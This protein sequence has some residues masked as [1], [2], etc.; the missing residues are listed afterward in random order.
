M[1]NP[2]PPGWAEVPLGQ[3]AHLVRGVTYQKTEARDKPRPGYRPILRAANIQ[4]EGLVLKQDLIYLPEKYIRPGQFLQPGDVVICMSSGSPQLVGKA[5]QLVGA[6]S[7][8]F[9][10][11]CAVARFKAGISPQLAGYFFRSSRYRQLVR[12]RASGININNLRYDDLAQLPLPVPPWSEQPRLVATIERYFNRLDAGTAGLRQ[13]QA[14]LQRYQTA[15]L[16]AAV[17]GQLVSQDPAEESASLL[18]RRLLNERGLTSQASPPVS[19]SPLPPGWGWASLSAISDALAGYAFKSQDYSAEGFQLVKIGNVDR[20]RLDLTE[21]PTFVSRV[22]P[23]IEQKYLLQQGDILI[24]LTGTRRK[25]D[26]GLV[27]LI[28][29]EERL[30]LNQ[31]VA[32]LRFH[33]PL[34]PRYF[35]LALQGDHFQNRF[36]QY[37][38]GNVG[39]GNVRMAALMGEAVPVPPLAEQARIVAEVERRLAAIERLAAVVEAN[40]KRAERLRQAILAKAFSGQ[41]SGR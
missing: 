16:Q 32:R 39:Q 12:A 14:K 41:L 38:T 26:Y 3:L 33:P 24:T 40:L 28:Q 1:T 31:R 11:F 27:A 35:L 23:K 6:W 29:A 7:G 34:D 4:A 8:S 25:R 17:S 19:A 13:V 5:A 2:L 36:F 15:V 30:L 9:G 37:E 21:K 10:A 22:E 18:L 20:G